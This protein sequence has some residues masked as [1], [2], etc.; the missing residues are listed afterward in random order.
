MLIGLGIAIVVL[1]I[2]IAVLLWALVD[3]GIGEVI[4][5]TAEINGGIQRLE[6]LLKRR[7]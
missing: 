4:T 5:N 7:G 2:V 3:I 6:E 1:L